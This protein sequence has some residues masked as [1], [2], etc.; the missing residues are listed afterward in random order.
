MNVYPPPFHATDKMTLLIAEICEEIG[1]ITILHK[2]SISPHLRRENR[3]RT[4]HSSLAIE[5]NT[6]S[7]DQVTAIL[8][9][10]RVLGNPL[11]SGIKSTS[12]DKKC[13][14]SLRI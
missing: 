14:V 6:L 10:K 2:G 3:I 1:R 12:T 5:Q 9:G 4:I 8:E 11:V 7:L 13:G